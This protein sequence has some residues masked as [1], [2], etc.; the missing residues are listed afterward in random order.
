[1]EIVFT[2]FLF[3]LYYKLVCFEQVAV[4]LLVTLIYIFFSKLD[5]RMSAE[6]RNIYST[7]SSGCI[8]IEENL[9]YCVFTV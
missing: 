9:G 7:E 1:M 5:I 6:L 4:K 3:L 8:A 2:T